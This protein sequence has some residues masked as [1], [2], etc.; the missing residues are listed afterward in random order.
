MCDQQS[1]QKLIMHAIL[2]QSILTQ[3]RLPADGLA[4]EAKTPAAIFRC[5]GYALAQ[6]RLAAPLARG[7]LVCSGPKFTDH[8]R[9]HDAWFTFKLQVHD[10]SRGHSGSASK[11]CDYRMRSC[12]DPDIVCESLN[13]AKPLMQP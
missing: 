13:Q 4:Q 3:Q 1:K 11:A 10:D 7:Q 2:G 6:D 9:S 12:L 5:L 8:L